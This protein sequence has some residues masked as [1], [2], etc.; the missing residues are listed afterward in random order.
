M[1]DD[2]KTAVTLTPAQLLEFAV[3]MVAH[4]T[5]DVTYENPE[6]I[7]DEILKTMERHGLAVIT[8]CDHEDCICPD[9][10]HSIGFW[11]FSP[12]LQATSRRSARVTAGS[13][14]SGDESELETNL[15]S[16]LL[17]QVSDLAEALEKIIAKH[18]EWDDHRDDIAQ[19]YSDGL[20]DCA[21]IA[22]TALSAQG[23]KTDG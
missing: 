1:Q 23:E 11:E 13:S 4:A 12:I 7:Q 2:M 10:D 6:D 21:D 8:L 16:S 15:H 3:E 18:A 22:R 9:P 5:E 19:G 20:R 14:Q 17:S